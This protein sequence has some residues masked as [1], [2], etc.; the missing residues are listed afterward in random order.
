MTSQYKIIKSGIVL[1]VFAVLV[2]V[3][4]V[5]GYDDTWLYIAAAAVALPAAFL[6]QSK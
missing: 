3:W 1:V 4:A 2:V 6:L 5:N